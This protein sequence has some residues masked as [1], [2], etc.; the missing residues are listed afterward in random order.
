MPTTRK[1]D[2]SS[3]AS[4]PRLQAGRSANSHCGMVTGTSGFG[5][6]Q[7][8][9]HAR[10]SKRQ[11]NSRCGRFQRREQNP[12]PIRWSRV[13]VG[14]R[15]TGN[16]STHPIGGTSFIDRFQSRSDD[17]LCLWDIQ[18]SGLWSND[19][20]TEM[21][22]WNSPMAMPTLPWLSCR[23]DNAC[24]SATIRARAWWWSSIRV[25]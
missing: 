10:Q 16:E 24:Y 23:T 15:R 11:R 25:R 17:I 21:R 8:I 9:Q 12:V 7:V 2:L 20:D 13:L 5:S 22:V 6:R 1:T 3:A 18:Q 14:R 19:C 4:L